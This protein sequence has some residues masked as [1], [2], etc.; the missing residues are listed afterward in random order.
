M[1]LTSNTTLNSTRFLVISL[2][3]KKTAGGDPYLNLE[4]SGPEY[5]IPGRVWSQNIPN[6][7]IKPG[8]IIELSGTTKQFQDSTYID[9][10][11]AKPVDDDY[12]QYIHPQPTMVFDIETLGYNWDDLTSEQQDYLENNLEKNFDGSP[13]Q[14]HDRTALYPLFAQVIAIGVYNPYTNKGQVLYLGDK[15]EIPTKDFEA[16]AF[17]TEAQLITAFWEIASKYYRFVTYNGN[18]F[19]FPF[20]TFRSALHHIKVPFEIGGNSDKYLDLATK[21]RMHHRAFKLE[22]LCLALGIDNPKQPGVSG[23]EVAHL[24]RA[25][26]MNDII[27]YVSR[28]VIATADL[29]HIYRKYTAGKII[30]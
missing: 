12:D 17:E 6:V 22:Q 3:T 5:T 1:N 2:N 16:L 19:D 18:G 4:L 9:I 15:S 11:S 10:T 7:E 20:L 27:D 14:K 25:G 23:Q 21:F 24:H 13:Q 29:Y 8:T 30:I 28:D 26:K